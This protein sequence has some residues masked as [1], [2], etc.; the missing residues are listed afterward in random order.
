MHLQ[1][2]SA[3]LENLCADQH[4]KW[5]YV[6][7]RVPDS[8][9]RVFFSNLVITLSFDIEWG[10]VYGVGKITQNAKTFFEI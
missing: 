5:V 3:S 2:Q 4:S 6:S 8:T 9:L 1:G 7:V 10:N